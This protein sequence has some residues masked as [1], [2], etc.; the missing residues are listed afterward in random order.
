MEFIGFIGVLFGLLAYSE[1]Q[2]LK[3]RVAELE[4]DRT[5]SQK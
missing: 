1:V 3:K 5:D 4:S 2:S